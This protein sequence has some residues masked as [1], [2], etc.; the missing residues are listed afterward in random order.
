MVCWAR[1][2]SA[3][4]EAA[5]KRQIAKPEL[6]R[7][8]QR[9]PQDSFNQITGQSLLPDDFCIASCDRITISREQCPDDTSSTAG[10]WLKMHAVKVLMAFADT[11]L[12]MVPKQPFPVSFEVLS[13][14][15]W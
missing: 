7:A 4:P 5:S 2:V 1:V 6:A 15:R 11:L 13:L 3:I 12:F 14:S 9:A 10:V 8:Q